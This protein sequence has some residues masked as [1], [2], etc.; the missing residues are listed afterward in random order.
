MIEPRRLLTF[1]VVVHERSFSHAARRL[2]PT[3]PAVSQQVRAL[4]LQLGERLLER[5]RGG[6][7][8]TAAGSLLLEHADALHARLML[9]ERQV[10]ELTAARA[11]VLRLGAFPSALATI[12]PA[13]IAELRAVE[14]DVTVEAEQG[15]T[16]ALVDGVRDGRLHLALAFQ[17]AAAPRREHDGTRRRDLLTEPLVALLPAGHRLAR[18]RRLRLEELADEVWTAPTPDGL[19]VRACRAAGL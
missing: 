19:I 7:R 12:V 15:S 14:P 18:R 5:D 17:D 13:A 1:R 9:A 4:E 6:L 16:E 10:A 8:L 3:Q 11:S 2:A